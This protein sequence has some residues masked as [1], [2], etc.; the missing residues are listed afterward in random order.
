MERLESLN[1][2]IELF[3]FENRK[4]E[5]EVGNENPTKSLRQQTKN[6]PN[7]PGLYFVFSEKKSHNDLKSHLYF[8][9]EQNEM[10]LL[11]FGKAGGVTRNGKVLKQNLLG[12][13]NNVVNED[14]PRARYWN[15]EMIEN[16]ESKFIVYF[17]LNDNPSQIEKSIYNYFDLNKLPYPRLNKKLGRKI[18]I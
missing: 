9:L 14:V 6:V 15:A 2:L 13:I 7:M 11:Y 10:E 17:I 8:T 5:F 3:D 16:K 18:S 1:Q 4:F 12:R